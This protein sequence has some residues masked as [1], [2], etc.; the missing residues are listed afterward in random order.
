LIAQGVG[1]SSILFRDKMPEVKQEAVQ[2]PEVIGCVYE[3]SASP[4]EL[5]FG[6]AV[7][8]W[9]FPNV[10]LVFR[11]RPNERDAARAKAKAAWDAMLL[12]QGET[13]LSG[14]RYVFCQP[15]QSP[16]LLRE[17][18]KQRHYIACNYSLQKEPS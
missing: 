8:R 16:F 14:T 18:E 3:G 15:L 11:G 9:E 7:A 10:Q 5:E 12:I 2:D 13:T 4:P 1:T 6:A 17:D